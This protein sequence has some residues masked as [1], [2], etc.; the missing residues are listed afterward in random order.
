MKLSK[1]DI[2]LLKELST[3]LACSDDIHT[4]SLVYYPPATVLRRQATEIE[5]KD[6]CIRKFREL[7]ERV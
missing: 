5:K 6:E 3:Y 1:E 7:L 2:E 4:T